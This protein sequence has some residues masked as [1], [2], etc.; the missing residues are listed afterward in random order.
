LKKD[1]S[2][3]HEQQMEQNDEDESDQEENYVTNN[4]VQTKSKVQNI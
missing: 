4:M 2:I 1:F 3:I